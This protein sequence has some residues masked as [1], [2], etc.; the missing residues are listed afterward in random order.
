MMESGPEAGTPVELFFAAYQALRYARLG[1]EF[2]PHLRDLSD[3]LS[4]RG[5]TSK[6]VQ[7][8]VARMVKAVKALRRH[9]IA[10]T[11]LPV[12]LA[13]YRE[14]ASDE[15]RYRRVEFT[16]GRLVLILGC[17]MRE[18]YRADD[19]AFLAQHL[20]HYGA[21]GG[22]PE[23]RMSV[24]EAVAMVRVAS[25]LEADEYRVGSGDVVHA[26]G[27][28]YLRKVVRDN[29]EVSE[30]PLPWIS[31]LVLSALYEYVHAES[32]ALFP[33]NVLS[34]TIAYARRAR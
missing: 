23:V 12:L 15:T 33:E 14:L 26:M 32:W 8:Q 17:G 6:G 21:S 19:P 9:G 2:T 16:A 10:V 3:Q 27:P 22:A 34:A 24:S 13:L 20:N 1:E 30:L 28:A 29:P 31:E 5:G 18:G 4:H 7:A 25:A 11:G